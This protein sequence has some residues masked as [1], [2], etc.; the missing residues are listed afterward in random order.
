VFP[1]YEDGILNFVTI[2][3]DKARTPLI[4]V[5]VNVFVPTIFTLELKFNHV[6]NGLSGFSNFSSDFSNSFSWATGRPVFDLPDGYTVNGFGIEDNVFVIPEPTSWVLVLFAS[7][8]LC[9]RRREIR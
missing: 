8:C 3:G 4:E 5:P 6:T 9:A 2:G 1:T 7:A